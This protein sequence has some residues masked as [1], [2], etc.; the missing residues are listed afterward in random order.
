MISRTRAF[1][2]IE[3]LVVISIIGILSSVVLA[4]L[5]SARAKARDVKRIADVKNLQLALELYFDNY[6]KYPGGLSDLASTYIPTIPTPPTGTSQAA[7]LYVPTG[8][9]SCNNYHLGAI[10]E[11]STNS[12]LSNDSDSS[13]GTVASNCNTAIQGSP[14][15]F[16]GLSTACTNTVGSDLC[17]DVTP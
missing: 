15:E 2:L 6:R 8:G 9:S 4:N 3:L 7:Y 17:Y 12:E 11:Q 1:T 10:L 5:N 16:N 14:V 13:G